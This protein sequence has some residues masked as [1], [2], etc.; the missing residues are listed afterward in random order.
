MGDEL[1]LRWQ[2]TSMQACYPLMLQVITIEAK[3]NT[4]PLSKA[5]E[6]FI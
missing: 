1:K 3:V 6:N 5:G 4:L 2:L